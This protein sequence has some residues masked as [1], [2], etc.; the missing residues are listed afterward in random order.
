MDY[1]TS[2]V[3][4]ISKL[5]R[6]FAVISNATTEF[7][8]HGD[9]VSL[10]PEKYV[11]LMKQIEDYINMQREANDELETFNDMAG[12]HFEM[13]DI[14]RRSGIAGQKA[15]NKLAQG[16]VQQGESTVALVTPAKLKKTEQE[17]NL[18]GR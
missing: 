8:A 12:M 7:E 1:T 6:D 13:K 10:L 2:V 9:A 14:E 15:K 5:H 17:N 3:K 16:R 11:A 18:I 4:E